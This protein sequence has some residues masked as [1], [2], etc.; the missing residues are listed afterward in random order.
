MDVC[1][2]LLVLILSGEERDCVTQGT[3]L[4]EGVCD[5]GKGVNNVLSDVLVLPDLM[6]FAQSVLTSET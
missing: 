1:R 2:C 6:M 3:G 5:N 4:R